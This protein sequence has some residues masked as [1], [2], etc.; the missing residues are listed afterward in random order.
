LRVLDAT[1]QSTKLPALNDAM[2]MHL[3]TRDEPDGWSE[4]GVDWVDTA[5]MLERIE[6]VR[7]LSGNSDGS[8]G[9]NTLGFLDSRGLDTPQEI[10]DA[11][12]DLLFQGALPQANKDLLIGHLT[13]DD[14][15]NPLAFSRSRTDFRTRVQELIGLML[16]MPQ[17]NF[18]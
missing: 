3:F 1:A 11:F 16:S 5:T 15:G 2:G 9:W 17:W 8:Y 18:Q 14:A 12:S 6:F 7:A 10:V 13:T 4:L